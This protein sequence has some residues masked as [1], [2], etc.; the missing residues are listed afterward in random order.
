MMPTPRQ[1]PGFG[2]PGSVTRSIVTLPP[3]M[4]G[5]G[6]LLLFEMGLGIQAVCERTGLSRLS[7]R[8]ALAAPPWRHATELPPGK[9]RGVEPTNEGAEQ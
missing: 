5:E 7:I 1:A 9:A 2:T 6:I 8:E 3:A 4:R